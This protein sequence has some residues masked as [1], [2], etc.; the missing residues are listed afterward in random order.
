MLSKGNS[1]Y[2]SN[3]LSLMLLMVVL[4]LL[5]TMIVMYTYNYLV[6]K[7]LVKVNNDKLLHNINFTEA[8]ALTMLINTLF[9]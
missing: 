8:F 6:P 9:T 4:Y 5:K 1:P 3:P 7:I 2:E